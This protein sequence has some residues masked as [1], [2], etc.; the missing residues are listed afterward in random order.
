MTSAPAA[1]A[2]CRRVVRAPNHLGDV[3]VALPALAAD[4]GDVL[5]RSWLAPLVEM[6]GLPGKTLPLGP[7]GRGWW[8]AVRALRAGGY[9]EGGL[10]TPSFSAAWLFRWGGVARLRGTATDGRSWLLRERVPREELR[11]HHRINQ[12]RLILGQ[13]P[14]LEPRYHR[15]AP[16]SAV[17]EA[18]AGR[19][20]DGGPWVG[21]V[22]GS[23]A[24][25]RRWPAER[26]A[27]VARALAR[28]GARVVVVGGPAERP[29]TA[30]VAEAAPGAV[31]AGGDTDLAGL[32]ALLSLCD[33]VVSNDTG[34]MHLAAS[35][36]VPT[37][38]LWGPSPPDEAAP[39]GPEH[40]RVEGPALPCRPCFRNAC[41]RAGRG[42]MLAEARDECLHLIQ[43]DQVTRAVEA[44]LEGR[45]V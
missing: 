8:G 5:V 35:V 42:T 22:P 23:N 40:R 43:E 11:A 31:D 24:P 14:G 39:P 2:G 10:L 17:V 45:P 12:Y 4:G 19:L 1:G 7:G 32:A 15:L 9:R 16:P 3:V 27:G 36:G 20:G 33:V 26:F 34:P 13:D 41:P 30:R 21:F 6:A 18:W 38:T 37:V 29:V 28:R 44:L 25:S